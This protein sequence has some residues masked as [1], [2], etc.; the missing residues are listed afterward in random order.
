MKHQEIAD[1]KIIFNFNDLGDLFYIILKGSVKIC[2]P[3][4]SIMELSYAEHQDMLS[5]SKLI[6]ISELNEEEVT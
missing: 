3:L 6:S 2:V 4:A 1:N 5:S